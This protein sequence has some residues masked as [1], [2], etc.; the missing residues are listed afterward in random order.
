L[1]SSQPLVPVRCLEC[2]RSLAPL[3]TRDPYR[4][5]VLEPARSVYPCGA[6]VR[7]RLCR[8]CAAGEHFSEHGRLLDRARDA[9]DDAWRAGQTLLSAKI[10]YAMMLV[11]ACEKRLLLA[12]AEGRRATA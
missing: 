7:S 1:L 6:R 5:A 2:A 11:Q 10:E 9:H 3:K 8:A 4:R 12:H